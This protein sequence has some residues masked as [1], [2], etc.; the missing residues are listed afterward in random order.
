LVVTV[1]NR[2]G[3]EGQAVVNVK[4]RSRATGETVAT[5]DQT[6]DLKAHETAQVT[7]ELR[8]AA[9]GPYDEMVEVQYPAR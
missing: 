8:P 4:L 2:G 9:P 3:G 6:A 7:V 5:A 1:E